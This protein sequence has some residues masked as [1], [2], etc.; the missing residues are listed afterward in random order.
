MTKNRIREFIVETFL[1]GGA[2]GLQD[3]ESLLESGTIDS[4]GVLELVAFVEG[5]FDI[6]VLDTDITRANFDSVIKLAKYV[7]G[8]KH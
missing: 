6:Q 8:K 1:Y 7:D 3:E 2:N 5:A 4:T